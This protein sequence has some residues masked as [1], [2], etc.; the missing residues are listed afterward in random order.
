MASTGPWDESESS[1]SRPG[2]RLPPRR[3]T[4]RV[5]HLRDTPSQRRARN[6]A[7]MM[8]NSVVDKV[9][10]LAASLQATSEVLSTADRML[11]H[12][13]DLNIEQDDEINKLRAELEKSADML[14]R[15]RIAR[16]RKLPT[17]PSESM[18]EDEARPRRGQ[19]TVRFSDDIRSDVDELKQV[20]REIKSEQN[21]LTGG[22]D[23]DSRSLPRQPPYAREPEP[24]QPSYSR[25]PDEALRERERLLK[26]LRETEE[27]SRRQAEVLVKGLDAERDV[28]RESQRMAHQREDELG[29]L[30]EQLQAA[31]KSQQGEIE[32]RL[33][34]IQQ[35]MRSEREMWERKQQ[36]VGDLTHE[37]RSVRSLLG[38]ATENKLK[39]DLRSL[40]NEL[41]MERQVLQESQHEKRVLS[42]RVDDLASRL[43]QSERERKQIVNELD[44]AVKK[45][46][47]ADGGKT[48]LSQQAEEM[49]QRLSRADQDKTELKRQLDEYQAKLRDNE[50]SRSRLQQRLEALQREMSEGQGDR[51]RLLEQLDVLRSQVTKAE[52]E[53][54][55][56]MQ[57]VSMVTRGTSRRQSFGPVQSG[58]NGTRRGT[59]TGAPDVRDLRLNLDRIES[60]L[61]RR[62][63]SRMDYD[64]SRGFGRGDIDRLE[65]SQN[66]ASLRDDI[67]RKEEHQER[68][69]EQMR[70]LL[71]K[72][73]HSEGQKK[74]L[75]D[76]LQNVTKKLKETSS[77]YERLSEEL[78]ERE[79]LLKES[80]KKRN[81]LKNKALS[82]LKEYRV[83]CKKLEREAEQGKEAMERNERLEKELRELRSLMNSGA[84]P[85][86][87][88][89]SS[90]R[91]M[92]DLMDQRQRLH[93]EVATKNAEIRELQAVRYN[94]E[95]DMTE[96]RKHIEKLE[97]ELR[98][99]QTQ[100][101][102]T[103]LEKM[104]LEEALQA[105]R[106]QTQEAEKFETSQ[107]RQEEHLG[108]VV[109]DQKKEI[110]ELRTKMARM[111]AKLQQEVEQ[112]QEIEERFMELRD[113]DRR[114]REEGAALYSQLQQERDQH[115]DALRDLESQ[116][117]SLTD[118]N[119]KTLQDVNN[120][121]EKE[122]SGLENQLA[123]LKLQLADEKSTIKA[124]RK[125]QENERDTIERLTSDVNNLTEDNA[126]LRK[127]CEN[128]KEE[129]DA[130][131]EKMEMTQM[132]VSQLEES[133]RR[134]Q[135]ALE[136]AAEENQVG[137]QKIDDNLDKIVDYICKESDIPL[138]SLLG[139]GSVRHD[140]QQGIAEM[141]GKLRW[142]NEELKVHLTSEKRARDQLEVSNKRIREL[143]R[144][145]DE[146]KRY[147][148]SEL[149]EQATLLDDLAAQ[150]KGLESKHR[151][152]TD[153]IKTLQD[154]IRQLTKHLEASTK[155]LHAG[156]EALDDK[157][158][159][160]DEIDE[161]KDEK[162][163][164]D[165]IHDRYVKYK[166]KVGSLRRELHGAKTIADD[167]KQESFEA[168]NLSSRLLESLDRISSPKA[169]QRRLQFP[170]TP[171]TNIRPATK[172]SQNTTDW[173]PTS[174]GMTSIMSDYSPKSERKRATRPSSSRT[175]GHMTYTDLDF[176]ERFLAM[177]RD[178]FA[179]AENDKV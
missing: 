117:K 37:L 85:G 144:K 120:K 131:K 13:R 76:E 75:A 25:D 146:E 38:D 154:R 78:G 132:R 16:R 124:L 122:R 35:E 136:K 149:D 170:D 27:A 105:A 150:K 140:S 155:A 72:Y 95:R 178:K 173:S 119:E 98:V 160:I 165:K 19:N 70:D 169:K 36:E 32:Q 139:S 174:D 114:S 106:Q 57:Q 15:E 151:Q 59:V 47:Q 77:E 24:R 66:L 51:Q 99:Y 7:P 41:E 23:L 18:S 8:A 34:E 65:L 134:S 133:L 126:R 84:A 64:D 50:A 121:T 92:D 175:P 30:R 127:R 53:K 125:Q 83:K 48:A 179:V 145:G 88:F 141:I 116:I 166:E 90:R 113:Q 62:S 115:T 2:T 176:K 60:D 104:K 46:D 138:P 103:N 89:S 56:I 157:Q 91:E 1:G 10:D 162:Q 148:L 137:W 128:L 96:L 44:V 143:I 107:K 11:E 17:T 54:D 118:D 129:H 74:Q 4:L 93:E 26:E 112:R 67:D 28:L 156:A 22:L 159:V 142:V 5:S 82:S 45:L 61:T 9:D 101:S 171:P 130:T 40:S 81:E 109:S 20:L 167:F 108:G 153:N 102:S 33:K 55:E 100:V 123:D 29:T 172:S 52:R 43:E 58:A 177:D 87:S 111:I 6:S 79:N 42:A 158:R 161:L 39:E 63:G 168:A 110:K 152:N 12:Y 86:T 71:D 21:R 14:R 3:S 80:E 68:L 49:R 147:F 163:E 94:G 73:D 135:Y 164:R 97:A 69:I 31:Q